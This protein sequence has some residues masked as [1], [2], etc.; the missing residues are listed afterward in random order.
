MHNWVSAINVWIFNLS[1][2]N[3]IKN[4]NQCRKNDCY[5][6]LVISTNLVLDIFYHDSF[7]CKI[8]FILL[9]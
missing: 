7:T 2:Q 1:I 6:S 3:H 5:I 9:T 8:T 4:I